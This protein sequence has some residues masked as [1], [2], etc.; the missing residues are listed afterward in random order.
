MRDEYADNVILWK[1]KAACDKMKADKAKKA[2]EKKA[3]KAKEKKAKETEEERAERLFTMG[4]DHMTRCI[5]GMYKGTEAKEMSPHEVSGMM[6][7]LFFLCYRMA[8]VDA[9]DGVIQFAMRSAVEEMEEIM[10]LEAAY[11]KNSAAEEE[12]ENNHE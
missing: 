2:K 4:V 7:R 5:E 6:V 10:K 11:L 1:R 8:G 9:T 12:E 3:K